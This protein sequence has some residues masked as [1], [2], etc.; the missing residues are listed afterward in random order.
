[1]RRYVAIVS[2]MPAN[3]VRLGAHDTASL[4]LPDNTA[5]ED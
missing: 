3:G 4:N 5:R 2:R 1:M